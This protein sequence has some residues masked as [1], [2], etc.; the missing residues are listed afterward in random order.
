[1]Q[2]ISQK[3]GIE[4]LVDLQSALAVALRAVEDACA[5]LAEGQE[6]L[7]GL[8]ITTKSPGDITTDID[9]RAEEAIKKRLRDSFPEF[10]FTGEEGGTIE[11]SSCHWIVDPLDG[12]LNY[13]HGFPFYAV[14]LSLVVEGTIAL[15]VTADPVRRET[16]WAV[17]G[18]GAYRNGERIFVSG[19][20]SLIEAVVGTVVPPPGRS[21]QNRYLEKFCSVAASAGGVRRCGAA[22]LDLAYVASGRLDGFFVESLKPW[23]IA[24]GM[25]LVTE[26]G[27][28]VADVEGQGSP[29]E[30]DRLVAANGHIFLALL[31]V[32]NGTRPGGSMYS[33][34]PDRF[35]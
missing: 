27:G 30:T 14:T 35:F 10:S 22:A 15:G 4:D 13:A 25:L 8:R 1:M 5:I 7:D 28:M 23:D 9:R 24:A 11:G 26:A 12:S 18:Q 2:N 29:L 21:G 33:H 20:S 32:L 16:F 17:L 31:D 34:D 3:G 19:V 6:R